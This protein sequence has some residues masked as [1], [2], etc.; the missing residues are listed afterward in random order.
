MERKGGGQRYAEINGRRVELRL[1]ETVDELIRRSGGMQS[2][3]HVLL[4]RRGEKDKL[5]K[6]DEKVR[7]G[8]SLTTLPR[9]TKGKAQLTLHANVH[10]SRRLQAEL[11]DLLR[12]LPAFERVELGLVK[13]DG[14]NWSGLILHNARLSP[15]KF[16][17][18][19]GKV[20]FLLPDDYPSRP[21]IGCYLN[22]AHNSSD[23]HFTQRTYHGAPSM[24]AKGWYWYCVGIGGFDGYTSSSWRPA[25]DPGEGHNLRRLVKATRF[26][27]ESGEIY[28]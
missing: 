18:S 1:G 20:L 25:R 22:Y 16:N 8:D 19:R 28:G 3:E 10:P 21:P 4:E 26:A 9:V 14:R 11:N 12:M 5:A 23:S 24:Q 7:E 13:L 2:D 6:P 27:L 15:E 17:T